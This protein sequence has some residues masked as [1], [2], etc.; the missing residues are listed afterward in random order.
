MLVIILGTG[1]E[2]DDYKYI[3][4]KLTTYRCYN[5]NLSAKLFIRVWT[6]LNTRDPPVSL[7]SSY[8]SVVLIA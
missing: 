3:I 2:N 8:A 4:I 1:L 5:Y 7:S 6:L